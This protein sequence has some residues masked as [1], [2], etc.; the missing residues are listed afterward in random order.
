[1]INRDVEY[2]DEFFVEK[3]VK[4]YFY[5][6]SRDA[7]S[8]FMKNYEYNAGSWYIFDGVWE[9]KGDEYPIHSDDVSLKPLP[10]ESYTI[11]GIGYFKNYDDNI[12]SVVINVAMQ[13]IYILD[14]PHIKQM[15]EMCGKETKMITISFREVFDPNGTAHVWSDVLLNVAKQRKER[16]DQ[17]KTL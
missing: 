5:H 8:K 2:L 1:M 15:T 16:N 11:S 14:E 7:I 6:I 13:E 17:T 3:E 9:L 12:P 4:Q 10:P